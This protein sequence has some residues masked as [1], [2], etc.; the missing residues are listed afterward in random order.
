[1]FAEAA[2][3]GEIAV[4]DTVVK[5]FPTSDFSQVLNEEAKK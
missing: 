4:A 2:A 5:N 1:L 3:R